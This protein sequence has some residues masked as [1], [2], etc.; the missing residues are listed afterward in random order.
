M[1]DNILVGVRVRPLITREVVDS[2]ALHW[3]IGENTITQVDPLTNKVIATPYAFGKFWWM[4]I[5]LRNQ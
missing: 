2:L 4:Y 1:S 5:T 3:Q